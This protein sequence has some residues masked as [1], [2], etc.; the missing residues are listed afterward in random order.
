[1][2]T[3]KNFTLAALCLVMVGLHLLTVL[4]GTPFYLTQLTMAAYYGL[5]IIGL[6]VLMG[7]A[8]QISIGHAGFF[9]IGG[10]LAAALTTRNLV[11]VSR[12]TGGAVA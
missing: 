7:Y 4:T 2:Q 6:G 8:G 10:Y 1:M 5:V 9:A 11:A 3:R 12:R